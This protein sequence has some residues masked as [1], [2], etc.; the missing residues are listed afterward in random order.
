LCDDEDFP[1]PGDDILE[2]LRFLQSQGDGLIAHDVEARLE[3]ALRRTV[4][5]MVRRDE[6]DEV[7][8]LYERELGFGRGHV[9]VAAVE[10]F[11]GEEEI[12]SGLVRT[13]GVRGEGA[14]DELSLAI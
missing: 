13:L 11:P 14:G 2:V 7:E 1:G 3:E 4:V 12:G 6:G 8:A 9:L 10:T 5:H